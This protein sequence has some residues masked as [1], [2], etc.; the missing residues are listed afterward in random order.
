MHDRTARLKHI[1]QWLQHVDDPMLY[2]PD[3]PPAVA[4]RR[5]VLAYVVLSIGL[6][7]VVLGLGLV[8]L[9]IIV[10]PVTWWSIVSNALLNLAVGWWNLRL[11]QQRRS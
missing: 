10:Q 5:D 4:P 9:V 11:W 1:E 8:A 2:F 7:N 6:A 3:A